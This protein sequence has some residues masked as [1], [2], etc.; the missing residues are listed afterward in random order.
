MQ[1]KYSICELG[2]FTKRITICMQTNVHKH[3]EVLDQE[4]RE[5]G[6]K[7][8]NGKGGSD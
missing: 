5:G 3:N 6:A 4:Q 7:R 8:K 1:F 2:F